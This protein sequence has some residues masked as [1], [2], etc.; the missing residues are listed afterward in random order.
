MH[1]SKL[2][3]I[4]LRDRTNVSKSAY[5][6]QINLCVAMLK[7]QKKDYY[8]NLDLGSITDNKKFWNNINPLFSDTF[9]IK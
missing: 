1:R 3:N 8:N 5:N 6:K 7:M 2:R 4:Y 9:K